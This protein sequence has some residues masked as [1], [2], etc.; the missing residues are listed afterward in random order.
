MPFIPGTDATRLMVLAQKKL[1][2]TNAELGRALG[3]S[4]R[5]VVRWWGHASHPDASVIARLAGAVHPR[6]AALAAGL[7]AEAGHTLESLGLAAPPPPPPAPVAEQ[8]PSPPPRPFP[9][10]K[11]LVEAVVGTAAQAMQTTPSAVRGAVLAAFA[12]ARGLG[13]TVEEV[14]TALTPTQPPSEA[15]PETSPAE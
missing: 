4:V 13:L 12:C 7:A 10:A 3:V 8:P 14:E 5:T 2:M 6:D 1:G 9:P 11:L 15:K